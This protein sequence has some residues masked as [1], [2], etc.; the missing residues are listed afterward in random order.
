MP[1]KRLPYRLLAR[2][3]LSG[4][5]GWLRLRQ[6]AYEKMISTTVFDMWLYL[7]NTESSTLKARAILVVCKPSLPFR[8][9]SVVNWLRV[10]DEWLKSR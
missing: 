7:S 9:D 5:G 2:W 8:S 4:E 1:T 6:M 10:T 3:R